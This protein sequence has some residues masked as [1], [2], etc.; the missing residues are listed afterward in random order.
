MDPHKNKLPEELRE[1]YE[2]TL[3]TLFNLIRV[4]RNDAGHPKKAALDSA[5]VKAE[6][7][8]FGHY[9]KTVTD[10]KAF[11]DQAGP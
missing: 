11:F 9:L 4:T 6:L 1:S 8:A 3:D 10:L 5:L 7:E 2:T